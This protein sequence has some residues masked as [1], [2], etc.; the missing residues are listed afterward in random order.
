MTRMWKIDDMKNKL[1]LVIILGACLCCSSMPGFGQSLAFHSNLAG[2]HLGGQVTFDIYKPFSSFYFHLKRLQAPVALRQGDETE[3]YAQLASRLLFPSYV[4]FQVTGYPLS[5]LSSYLET[6]RYD[7]FRRFDVYQ[8]LNLLRSIGS[9]FEE[10]YAF[11]LLLG[12]ILFLAYSDSS[13]KRLKQSG[14]ALAGL[15]I[16]TGKHQIYNNIS[17]HDFW[18]QIE[19]MLTGSLNEPQRRRIHWN[20][21]IGAKLHDNPFF[22]DM[23]TLSVERSHTNWQRVPWSLLKNSVFK[24]QGHFPFNF[25]DKTASASQV[26]SYGKKLPITL[27]HRNMFLTLS[28]GIRWEKVRNYDHTR[29]HFEPYP[30]R[31]LVWLVQPNIEF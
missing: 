29:H 14:S 13:G 23:F 10:P 19:L 3:I 28:L 9:G 30:N 21:R 1:W 11:S 12:N 20:F 8:D 15:L 16:S 26:I 17:L 31:Q 6:N 5:A 4:L 2:Y 7:D 22:S 27:F 18:Y 24:Y 25:R